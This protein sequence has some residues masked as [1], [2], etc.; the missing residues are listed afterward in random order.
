MTQV[1]HSHPCN[2]SASVVAI[3]SSN[4]GMFPWPRAYCGV[5]IPASSSFDTFF[6]HLWSK[7]Q[8]DADHTC[9]FHV[10]LPSH[11]EWS[12]DDEDSDSDDDSSDDV[13]ADETKKDTRAKS[14]GSNARK[15]LP[16]IAELSTAIAEVCDIGL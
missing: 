7:P 1:C 5:G 13:T 11:A 8:F 4:V 6:R 9:V 2:A 12:D 3:R 10:S 16:G 14:R 15:S